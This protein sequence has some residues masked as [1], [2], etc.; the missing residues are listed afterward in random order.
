[1][2]VGITLRPLRQFPDERGAVLHMLRSSD[3]YFEQF[4]DIYFSTLLHGVVK[5]WHRHRT[6]TINLAVPVGRVRVVVFAG[7]G[8]PEEILLGRESYQLLTIRPGLWYG[9]QG[10]AEGESLIANCATEPFNNA[11]GEN[12]PS[13]AGQ[14]P[15][16]W[17][18]V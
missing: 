17:P 12:L 1:M 4:G 11:E 3:S 15:F 5:A 8:Q 6:K 16:V 7:A 13:D 14:I 18:A 9:F 2:T 10:L